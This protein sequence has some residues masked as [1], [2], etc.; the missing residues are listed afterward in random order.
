MLSASAVA[1]TVGAVAVVNV[2]DLSDRSDALYEQGLV[3]AQ[4]RSARRCWRRTAPGASCSTCSSRR[5]RPT[6]RTTSATCSPTTTRSPPRWR[7]TRRFPLD[8]GRAE[9]VE[10]VARE[11]SAYQ[12]VREADLMP[13]AIASKVTEFYGVN[14]A[15]ASVHLEAVEEALLAL[16]AIEVEDG[17]ALRDHAQDAAAAATRTHRR[18]PARRPRPGDRP[19][20]CTCRG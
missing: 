19:R 3:P 18:R 5:R 20:R 2:R 17:E 15:K 16:Q 12:A 11:W 13:L 6:S 1:G 8:G 14:E 7:S 4:R 9:H 10:A